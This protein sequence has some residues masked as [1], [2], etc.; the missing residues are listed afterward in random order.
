MINNLD[1][2]SYS[3]SRT[4]SETLKHLINN[5]KS[6][7][8]EINKFK[9]MNWALKSYWAP[10]CM[11]SGSTNCGFAWKISNKTRAKIR[12][13]WVLDV[14]NDIAIGFN[15]YRQTDSTK[16][17]LWWFVTKKRN[18]LVFLSKSITPHTSS[19]IF[20]VCNHNRALLSW[21][22]T[23]WNFTLFISILNINICLV[24]M[25][26]PVDKLSR[27]TQL[28]QDDQSAGINNIC[29]YF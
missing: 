2:S 18:S 26:Y 20:N 7:I 27:L 21:R 19:I 23:S 15:L 6:R 3:F 4:D 10:S 12:S 1:L 8:K 9:N 14:S 17:P 29:I 28:R 5:Q 24:G 16:I 13:S 22:H 25:V 11:K